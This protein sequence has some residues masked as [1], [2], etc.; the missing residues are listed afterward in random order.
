MPSQRAEPKTTTEDAGLS[1]G[2]SSH[3][4]Q[5]SAKARK[6][7]PMSIKCRYG[8]NKCHYSRDSWAL[9]AVR[10]R[11]PVRCSP[12]VLVRACVWLPET[13]RQIQ[14]G[15]ARARVIVRIWV[16]RCSPK[17]QGQASRTHIGVN[18]CFPVGRRSGNLPDRSGVI[19]LLGRVSLMQLSTG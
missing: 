18:F 17:A 11:S 5:L 12:A 7:T 13:P 15:N 10:C 6:Y 3:F 8:A 9:P 19:Y 16:L 4:G 14:T 2:K 1:F